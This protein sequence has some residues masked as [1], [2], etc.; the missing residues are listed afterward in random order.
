[1]N[2]NSNSTPPTPVMNFQGNINREQ[3]ERNRERA[4]EIA[5]QLAIEQARRDANNISRQ[6]AELNLYDGGSKRRMRRR[7]T[8]RRKTHRKR[9]TY[10]K[11]R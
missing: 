9:K 4:E 2:N 11:R 5:T 6:L 1:M 8:H 7:K 10:H 3:A